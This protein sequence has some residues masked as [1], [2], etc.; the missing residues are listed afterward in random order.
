[1]LQGQLHAFLPQPALP[2]GSIALQ[3][4]LPEGWQARRLV[5]ASDLA[6]PLADKFGISLATLCTVK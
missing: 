6:A 2:L 3:G 4:D 5:V 1:V